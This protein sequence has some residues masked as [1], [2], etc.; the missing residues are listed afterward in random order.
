MQSKISPVR[1]SSSAKQNA[2]APPADLEPALLVPRDGPHDK[3]ILVDVAPESMVFH[4]AG[5]DVLTRRNCH[6]QCDNGVGG[7][8]DLEPLLV[9]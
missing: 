4:P 5:V 8:G 9:C 6:S 7:T 2:V 1:R 3:T